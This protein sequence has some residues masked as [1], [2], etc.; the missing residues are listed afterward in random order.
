MEL[1]FGFPIGF[2]L[3][4]SRCTKHGIV[5]IKIPESVQN[6]NKNAIGP[7]SAV[8]KIVGISGKSNV[9]FE[10]NKVT[11]SLKLCNIG[12]ILKT[13]ALRHKFGREIRNSRAVLFF[14]IL[15]SV[16]LGPCIYIENQQ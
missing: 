9:Q 2:I 10:N 8:S 5:P 7:S 3:T 6:S 1:Y 16:D 12:T 13:S 4:Y 15:K 14:R 11:F